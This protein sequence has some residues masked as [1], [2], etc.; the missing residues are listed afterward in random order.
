MDSEGLVTATTI[1]YNETAIRSG[2]IIWS[3]SAVTVNG[4]ATFF[5]SS[6]GTSGGTAL[7]TNIFTLQPTSERNT[8]N[9]I[10]VP[11]YG[12]K[13]IS[14]DKKTITVNVVNAT[15]LIALGST[16]VFAPDGTKVYLIIIG[17]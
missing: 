8:S 14:A 3:G 12:I 5:P 1:I 11:F 4:V 9:A 13:S 16:L 15:T 10:D 17:N 2:I 7:F 6:D